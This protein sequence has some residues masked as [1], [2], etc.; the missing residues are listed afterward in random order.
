MH[1]FN[2]NLLLTYYEPSTVIGTKNSMVDKTETTFVLRSLHI[3][4]EGR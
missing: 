2:K 3:N 4:E 1:S